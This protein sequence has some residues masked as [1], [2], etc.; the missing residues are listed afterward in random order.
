[1]NKTLL[2]PVITHHITQ[3]NS[4]GLAIPL[5]SGKIQALK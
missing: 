1:M 3:H 4:A 5:I 2:K